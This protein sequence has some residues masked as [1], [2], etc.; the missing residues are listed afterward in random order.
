[1]FHRKYN[2]RATAF[3]SYLENKWLKKLRKDIFKNT[4]FSI[5]MQKKK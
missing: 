2:R 1:L 5:G 4:L 3:M